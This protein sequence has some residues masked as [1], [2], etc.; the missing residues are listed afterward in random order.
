MKTNSKMPARE[1][2]GAQGVSGILGATCEGSSGAGGPGVGQPCQ[3]PAPRCPA[4]AA[5]SLSFLIR[6]RG[7][8]RPPLRS[9]R[10]QPGLTKGW[11]PLSH[12]NPTFSFPGSFS[13][14]ISSQILYSL[15]SFLSLV[16]TPPGN[17]G[18]IIMIPHPM[19]GKTR[20]GGSGTHLKKSLPP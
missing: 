15:I 13:Q 17:S 12:L 20:P 16:E 6:A 8:H 10:T 19:D 3:L 11:L 18:S 14:S 1:A 9:I 7:W 2:T 4:G 5:P